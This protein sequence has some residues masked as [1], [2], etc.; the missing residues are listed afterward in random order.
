MSTRSALSNPAA[1]PVTA[2]VRNE[3]AGRWPVM[4]LA[5]NEERHIGKC[6]ESIFAAD[7][8]APLDAYVM[9]NGCTDATETIVAALSR[10]NPHIHLVSITLG[11]KCNAWNVF[12]HETVAQQCPGESIYFFVDGDAR[13]LPGSFSAMA[14]VL[15]EDRIANAVGAPPASGRSM[16]RDRG[17]LVRERGLVANLYAL[18]GSFVDRCRA[19]GVRIPLRLE[20]DDGLIG[21]L[22]RWDLDPR[23]EMDRRFIAPCPGA[24]FTFE[25]FSIARPADW[26]AYWKR[27]VRYGRRRYEFALLGPRLKAEGLGAMPRDIRD[28]YVD[29]HRLPLKWDGIYTLTNWFALRQM[30]RLAQSPD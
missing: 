26:R 8:G 20:G 11:D 19:A 7:P 17:E 21:A 29:A 23:R 15:Q 14:K 27:M 28:I 3:S 2:T 30:R 18:R 13:V 10:E 25:S 5:H 22:L 12:V 4:V 6:L 24:G 16:A 9:A 1:T